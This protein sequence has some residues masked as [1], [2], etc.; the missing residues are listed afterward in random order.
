M[1]FLRKCAYVYKKNQVAGQWKKKIVKYMFTSILL[2]NKF[3]RYMKP[4]IKC[5]PNFLTIEYIVV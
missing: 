3:S 5:V 1:Q 4:T 2:K